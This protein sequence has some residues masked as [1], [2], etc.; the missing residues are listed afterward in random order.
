MK[1]DL[2]ALRLA[3]EK[4]TP[5]EWIYTCV[6]WGDYFGPDKYGVS[7]GVKYGAPESDGIRIVLSP[8][9]E[10]FATN[11]PEN[12]KYIAAANPAT[13]IA[14]LDRLERYEKALEFYANI[15][16]SLKVPDDWDFQGM[17]GPPDVDQL[18][19][20]DIGELAREALGDG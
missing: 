7:I 11:K 1:L 3:A 15:A 14:L 2:K 12:G 8:Q 4:A 19:E 9:V 5:G 18:E 16:K 20:I 17:G 13:I 10:S 6:A